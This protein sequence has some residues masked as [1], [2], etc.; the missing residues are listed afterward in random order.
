[1]M[2]DCLQQLTLWDLGPQQ[3]TVTF[4]GGRLVSDTGLHG[5]RKLDKELGVLSLLAGRL[6]DP[7]MQSLVVHS[8]EALFTQ[9]VYQILA[10]YPDC[11]DAQTLRIDPLFHTLVDQPADEDAKP[12]ASGSTLARFAQA[13]TRREAEL[14]L[15]ERPVL[16]EVAV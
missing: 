6:P 7:R 5:M 13:F 12:L 16:L 10:G 14:P 4:Q 2:T 15:E 11:N 3:V 9:Q 8:R 1:M